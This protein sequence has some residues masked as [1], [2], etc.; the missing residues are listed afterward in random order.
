MA[1]AIAIPLPLFFPCFV[2]LRRFREN[3]T[4]PFYFYLS[5][6]DDSPG[7][8]PLVISLALRQSE[9]HSQCVSLAPPREPLKLSLLHSVMFHIAL[10]RS[11]T[12]LLYRRH[13]RKTCK[14]M[15]GILTHRDPTDLSMCENYMSSVVKA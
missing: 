10:S 7:G 5:R 12:V 14:R 3:L 6:T 4:K 11:V 9:T 2:L 13:R 8:T 15:C 1:S